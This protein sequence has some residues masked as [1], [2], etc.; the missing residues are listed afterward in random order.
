MYIFLI[1]R[2][3]TRAN[4]LSYYETVTRESGPAMTWSM[5]AIGHLRIG[6][7]KHAA[8]LF[9]DSYQGYVR[10]PFKVFFYDFNSTFK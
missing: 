1:R 7:S 3:S 9:K 2:R 10:E 6:N 5:H 4:D 8:Q